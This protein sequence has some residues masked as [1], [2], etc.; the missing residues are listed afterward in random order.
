[1]RI[2]DIL[3]RSDFPGVNHKRVYRLYRDADLAVRSRKMVKRPILGRIPLQ[4]AESINDVW[5]M[6]IVSDRPAN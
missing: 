6:D 3:D 5:S 4:V 2:H 1:M